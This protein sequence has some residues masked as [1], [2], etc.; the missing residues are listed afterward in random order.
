MSNIDWSSLG[1]GSS[2][3]SAPGGGIDW[4]S[5][6]S[7]IGGAAQPDNPVAAAQLT[8]DKYGNLINSSGDKGAIAKAKGAGKTHNPLSAA[9]G[10]LD[11]PR[12]AVEG[13]LR[14]V[15]HLATGRGFSTQQLG[16][17][18]KQ[19]TG[20]QTY[21]K[22]MEAGGGLGKHAAE[23]FDNFS[24]GFPLSGP[25]PLALD[26]VQKVATGKFESNQQL[27][28][29]A[30]GF[31]G[32]MAAD[33]L[34]YLGGGGEAGAA[35]GKVGEAVGLATKAD[36]A[37][38][39]ADRLAQV[40]SD[41]QK[42][43]TTADAA[44]AAH[45]ASGARQ[46]ADAA[47]M[48][49]HEATGGGVLS[50]DT[51]LRVTQKGVGGLNEAEKGVLGVK[52]GV[53]VYAPLTRT[54]AH[55]GVLKGGPKSAEL[56]PGA[57]TDPLTSAVHQ[58]A[59]RAKDTSV[60][61]GLAG[62]LVP[63]AAEKAELREAAAAGDTDKVAALTQ[64][65]RAAPVAAGAT[66]AFLTDHGKAL[67]DAWKEIPKEHEEDAVQALEGEPE[68]AG[69]LLGAGVDVSPIREA[70]SSARK[71]AVDKGVPVAE[72]EAYFPHQLTQEARDLGIS[73]AK[74]KAGAGIK[75][76]FE[77]S[78]ERTL[79]PG[80]TFLGRKLETGSIAEINGIAHDVMGKDAVDLFKDG[81][82]EVSH[83]YIRGLARAVGN[84]AHADELERLGVIKPSEGLSAIGPDTKNF[85]EQQEHS[86]GH[87]AD[88]DG[89]L[90]RI[91][92]EA[93]TTAAPT[94]PEQ[95]ALWEHAMSAVGGDKDS[96]ENWHDLS[97]RLQ[98]ASETSKAFADL[99]GAKA[100]DA[101]VRRAMGQP[102]VRLAVA[103]TIN[104]GWEKLA[105]QGAFADKQA[106]DYVK[107]TLDKMNELHKS[108]QKTMGSFLKYYDKYLGLWKNYQL[109]APG[110]MFRH[111]IGAVWNAWLG[112]VSGGTAARA[113]RIWR[114]SKTGALLSDEDR[115]VI[116]SFLKA[117]L[118]HGDLYQ[119]ADLT[120]HGAAT[121]N[122]GSR[123]FKYF[124]WNRE[125]QSKAQDYVRFSMFYDAV[126]KGTPDL[127]AAA[128]VRTM[129]GDPHS[130]TPFEK[131]VVRR[132]VPFYT[133]L[134][135]NMPVELTQ[136]LKQPGK[137]ED[138]ENL[139]NNVQ[140]NSKPNALVPSTFINTMGIR[141]P[142]N[143]QGSQAYVSPDLPF[144]RMG[145]LAA[146]PKQ[147]LAQA[148]PLFKLPIEDVE[149]APLYSGVP[150][151]P[152][153][154]EAPGTWSHIPGFMEVLSKIGLAQ[155][156][157]KSYT[158]YGNNFPAGSWTMTPKAE[159]DIE[160][161]LPMLSQARRLA[162]MGEPGFSDRSTST[163][164]AYA[165]GQNFRSLDQTQQAGVLYQRS[166]ALKSIIEQLQN[167]GELPS[168]LEGFHK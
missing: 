100:S 54:A 52:T 157:S 33:P 32:D 46:T 119:E 103:D 28:N 14:Q 40:A 59:N 2:L 34:N 31:L 62:K 140:A 22:N 65:L 110:K 91:K 115:K 41:V 53:H 88:L 143:F 113:F 81:G 86:A 85:A 92:K 3:G 7:T 108:P 168:Y 93:A 67:A 45:S 10:F 24:V 18:I 49:A 138:Y 112:N 51:L 96:A 106:P 107:N 161:L 122:P 70:L 145:E 16:Q 23:G 44:T 35:V 116:D 159:Y 152:T 155:K 141:L 162:P 21:L 29:T 120:G 25:I 94:T 97:T 95:K 1:A 64:T 164:L 137:F 114:A 104:D 57:L 71:A 151:S 77:G 153:A 167:K 30:G 13:T 99:M 9:L 117:G 111:Q 142:F 38:S 150:F 69:R 55:L 165:L 139:T 80:S 146:G 56:I 126:K 42:T 118:N 79:Q 158:D 135:V 87:A 76:K 47:S 37:A 5:L 127:E 8:V 148:S 101:E 98:D 48:A 134:R 144:T 73:A 4:S 58:I 75:A 12:A 109:A 154:K 17:D 123:D 132:V 63:N 166:A 121:W 39:E 15:E 89:Y 61:R 125:T 74:G 90:Q 149:N 66:Q 102:R 156:V 60:L 36:Q 133:F 26:A 84:K 128:K 20:T 11:E 6:G 68:A 124:K 82:R 83:N 129:M 136:M 130:L 78:L 105:D 163:Q 27:G 50:K 72:R 19:H 147:W 160:S 43:G 131:G